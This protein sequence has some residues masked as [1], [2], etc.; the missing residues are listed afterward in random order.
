MRDTDCPG[1]LVAFLADHID[2]ILALEPPHPDHDDHKWLQ[3]FLR[4]HICDW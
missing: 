3:D 1:E 2:D 4:D